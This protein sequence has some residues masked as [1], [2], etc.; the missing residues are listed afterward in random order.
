MASAGGVRLFMRSYLSTHLL[1]SARH[2]AA[3]AGTIEAAHVGRSRFDPEHC[4]YV[5]GAIQSA[6]AF[7]EAMINELFEDAADG[8]NPDGDGYLAPLDASVH[9]AM[10]TRWIERNAGREITTLEKYQVAL[11]AAAQPRMD[12]G[13]KLFQ[14]ASELMN[15][16]NQI[17]HFRPESLEAGGVGPL[18]ELEK[19]LRGR[20]QPNRLMAGSGN[21]WWASHCLGHG[22][23]QW[24]CDAAAAFANEFSGRMAIRPNYLG[25]E[26]DAILGAGHGVV[27]SALGRQSESCRSG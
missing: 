16:R 11:D 25:L 17:V 21:P 4:A 23:A 18:H 1:W 5:L 20:F 10:A 12:R 7:L 9:T 26:D 22:C 14:Q 13:S 8:H 24:G 6:A 27:S 2:F 15:L 19:R 3:L